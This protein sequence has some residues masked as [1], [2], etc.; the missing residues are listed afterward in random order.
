MNTKDSYRLLCKEEKSIPLFSQD[1]W[2][3]FVC[4]AENWDVAIVEKGGI[5]YATCPYFL[6]KKFPWMRLITMPLLTQSLGVWIRYPLGQKY[7]TKLK[8]EKDV[9]NEII[10]QF[11]DD[12]HHHNQNLHY[13]L[14][15]WLPFYW[16][17]YNQTTRYTYIIEDLTNLN[18]VYDSFMSNAKSDIKKAEK[19]VECYTDD[20]IKKF[21]EINKLTFDRQNENI[22]YSL[23]FL[24]KLHSLFKEH[25]CSKI[26]FAKDKDENI[27]AA[28]YIVWDSQSAYYLMGG[29]HPGL[30][31]SGATSLLLWEAIRFCAGVTKK[32]DFEGSMI[33]SVEHFFRSFGAI[34]KP[35]LSVMKDNK[36]MIP[37]KFSFKK[38]SNLRKTI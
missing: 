38:E 25:N 6:K 33:E 19:F 22:P 37:I 24:E 20:D 8:F 3:D 29:G 13:S 21:Y 27:H 18:A 11:P 9:L 36:S 14:S 16:H 1:W 35:Y 15:N 26:F 5:I 30:R 23:K 34:Q 2:L 28:L 31:H 10:V 12:I 4:G 17:G 7:S 32:F